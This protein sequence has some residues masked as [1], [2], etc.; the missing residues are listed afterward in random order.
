MAMRAE[1]STDIVTS[2]YAFRANRQNA[3][4]LWNMKFSLLV[5]TLASENCIADSRREQIP[6][7]VSPQSTIDSVIELIHFVLK[8]RI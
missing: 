7:L 2:V 6:E 8:T 4:E 3:V 1:S 5:G